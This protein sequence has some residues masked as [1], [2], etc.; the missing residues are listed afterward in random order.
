MPAWPLPAVVLPAERVSEPALPALV[1]PTLRLIEPPPEL[2]VPV[3]SVML[4]LLLP[5]EVVPVLMK[6]DPPVG[7]P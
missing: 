2:L 5:E 3:L 6:T 4:P 7:P 1:E